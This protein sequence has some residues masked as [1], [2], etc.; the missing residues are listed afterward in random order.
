MSSVTAVQAI[1]A[2]LRHNR[3]CLRHFKQLLLVSREIYK[4][5]SVTSMHDSFGV[6]MRG[7][8]VM[9]AVVALYEK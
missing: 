3:K 5:L 2:T 6:G 9:V 4:D 8:V 1:L 7:K